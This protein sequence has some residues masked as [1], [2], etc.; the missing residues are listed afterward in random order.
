[1][2]TAVED[3][4]ELFDVVENFD[5]AK[6]SDV[7]DGAYDT[8]SE[9]LNEI[10]S[11]SLVGSDMTL[12][13]GSAVVIS[14]AIMVHTQSPLITGLGLLQIVLSFP[15]AYFVYSL[16][17]GFEYFPFLNFIGVFVVFALGAGDIYVAF[18]KWTNY[19]K[20]N[21]D[22]S[23]EFVAAYALPESLSA[24]FLTTITTALAFFA[25]SVCPVAPIKMFAIFCGLLILL[26][27]LLVV[28]FI[29][30][31]LCIYDLA[32]LKRASGAQT[33]GCWMACVG[34]GT[35]FSSCHKT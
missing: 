12:A 10:K 11:D 4:Q 20:N 17:L 29:F 22:K 5:Q 32:L 8:G 27:Y 30:P 9:E 19:R 26:D 35:R 1:M 3:F 25:T 18:D 13:L 16:I 2:G 31:G 34:C 14:V 33:S 15:M 7:I 21:T 6:D 23:T 28:L 24:M